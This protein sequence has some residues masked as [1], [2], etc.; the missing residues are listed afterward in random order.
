MDGGPGRVAKRWPGVP[1]IPQPEIG[2]TDASF[3]TPVA[4]ATYGFTGMFLDPD[5]SQF[6]GLNE[7][8]SV[9]VL[10]EA[11]DYLYDL[12]RIYAKQADPPW[13]RT[14][15]PNHWSRADGTASH[16][17]TKGCHRVPGTTA[18][19]AHA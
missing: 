6:H 19:P 13:R 14:R 17:D 3:M 5:D 15:C 1:V 18:S 8:I 4:I 16:R 2:A 12:V 10:Y 7:R 11:R 9:R